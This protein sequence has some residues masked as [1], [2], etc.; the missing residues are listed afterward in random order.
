MPEDH[1]PHEWKLV[2]TAVGPRHRRGDGAEVWKSD[3]EFY[4]N[5]LNPRC[6]LWEGAGPGRTDYLNQKPRTSG[7]NRSTGQRRRFGTAEAAMRAVD[8]AY[9]PAAPGGAEAA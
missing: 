5:P 2:R 1:A 3:D 9:P 7:R 4:S 6:R 8:L